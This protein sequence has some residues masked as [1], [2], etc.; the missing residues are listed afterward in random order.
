[1][2]ISFIYINTALNN[3]HVIE[4]NLEKV[5]SFEKREEYVII[6]N[7]AEKIVFFIHLC[8]MNVS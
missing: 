3:F 2:H 7:E 8:A 4:N 1:M 6:V 5:H